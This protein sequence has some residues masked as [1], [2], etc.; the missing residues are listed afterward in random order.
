MNQMV[1]KKNIFDIARSGLPSIL[2]TAVILTIVTFGLRQT[3][4][5]SREEGLR[6]LEE[7]IRRAVVHAY[8]IEGRY[9][10]TLAYIEEHYGIFIDRNRYIVHYNIFATNLMPDITVLEVSRGLSG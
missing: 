5:S 3:E 8:T 10:D 1:F 4:I 9:P 6:L 2:F 7:S